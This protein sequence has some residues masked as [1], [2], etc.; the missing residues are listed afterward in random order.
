[1]RIFREKTVKS[2][3][4][5]GLRPEPLFT[6]GGELRPR[7][8]RCYSHLLLQLCLVHFYHIIHFIVLKEKNNYRTVNV[9]LL[10]LPQLLHLFFTLNSTV[11]VDGGA[12]IFLAPGRKVT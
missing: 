2:P 5:R 1:M 11:F 12:R 8:P 6:S 7:S 3:Q 9:L 4:Y 10:F